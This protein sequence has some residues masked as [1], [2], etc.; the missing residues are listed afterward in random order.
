MGPRYKSR[1]A[2]SVQGATSACSLGLL[3]KAPTTSVINPR[4]HMVFVFCLESFTC[5]FSYDFFHPD[6]LHQARTHGVQG[7]L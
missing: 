2:L 6:A 7:Q 1:L 5:W 3:R 4:A